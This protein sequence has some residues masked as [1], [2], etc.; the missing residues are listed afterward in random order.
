MFGDHLLGCGNGPWRIHRHDALRDVLYHA[1]R[2]VLYHALRDVLYHA[3]LQDSRNTLK[4]QRV[5]R[6]SIKG[7]VTSSIQTFQMANLLNLMC[8]SATH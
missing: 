6:E 7:Q 3:L 2:D 5:C 8:W 1:L 4:E